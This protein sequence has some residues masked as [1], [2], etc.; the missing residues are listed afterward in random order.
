MRKVKTGIICL[1]IAIG[2]LNGCTSQTCCKKPQDGKTKQ[3]FTADWDSLK[4]RNPAPEWF[5]DAKFGIYFHW[6]V[7]TVPAF[8]NEWYPR[9]MYDIHSSE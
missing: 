4:K 1:V 8:A 5:R 3:V 9:N 7:Y 6:G 2:L